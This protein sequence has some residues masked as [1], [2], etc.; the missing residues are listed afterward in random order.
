[1]EAENVFKLPDLSIWANSWLVSQIQIWFLN[2]NLPNLIL[3]PEKRVQ[4]NT[5]Y[6]NIMLD[7]NM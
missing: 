7:L 6:D 2:L 3:E 5:N 1:M 4:F